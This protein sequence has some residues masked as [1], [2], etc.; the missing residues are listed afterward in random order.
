LS[1]VVNILRAIVREELA[2]HR[3]PELGIVTE[4]FPG[5]GN[6]NNHQVSVR[7]RSSG[8]ELQRAPVS[9]GRLGFSMLPE[10]EDLV[11][12]A[13]VDG[14]INA[15]VVI[16]AIY[17]NVKQAPKAGALETIYQP[18]GDEDSSIRRL[19]VEL[20]SGSTLTMDD[21]K[22]QVESGGTKVVIERD[23]DV[24]IKSAAKVTIESS[25]D[26]TLDAGGNLELSAKQN[27]TI[28]GLST[29]VEGQADAKLKGP[30]VTLAG[31]TSFSA[32]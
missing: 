14:D 6:E 11:L 20:A 30:T 18:F 22:L 4:V 7:L 16:G 2:H 26:I 23:G 29:A 24:T 12:L 3:S 28:K 15:P 17:D 25:G 31:M 21:D 1:D 5:D 32:S 19:H 10:V 27:V 13:F 9:V 8:V